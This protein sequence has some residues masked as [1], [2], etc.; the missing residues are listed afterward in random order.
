MVSGWGDATTRRYPLAV[1]LV[2]YGSSAACDSVKIGPIGLVGFLNHGP[3][4]TKRI[5]VRVG[6]SRSIQANFVV[7]L[8]ID[9]KGEFDFIDQEYL[10]DD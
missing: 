3:F 6:A 10:Y 9:L 2:G 8:F 4:V 7:Y 1:F 5:A